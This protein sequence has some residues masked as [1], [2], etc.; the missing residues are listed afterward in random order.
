MN[1][2]TNRTYWPVSGG[3]ISFQPGWFQGHATAQIFINL[4]LGS[5]GP[6]GGP[7]NMSNPMVPQFGIIGPSKNPF[8]GTICLPQVPLPLN[9]TVQA[10]DNATI[11]IVELAIHGASLFS[12]SVR[13]HSFSSGAL[14]P[15]PAIL[16]RLCLVRGHHVRRR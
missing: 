3:A 5:G 2:T 8:P 4:G 9:T 1:L 10:G 11:Q 14:K 6:D 12:V 15:T 13:C 7:L 16:I